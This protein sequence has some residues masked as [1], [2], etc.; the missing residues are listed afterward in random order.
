MR[1]RAWMLV[2]SS[3]ERTNSSS[4]NRL[5]CQSR[6]YRSRIRPALAWNCGSRGNIQQRCCHGRM[7][8]SCSQRHTVLLLIFA[9]RPERWACRAT[10]AT[11]SRD[12]GRPS[13]AGNSQAS[14]LTS[15]VS[16]GGEG[17]GTS[18]ADPLFQ[19]RQS[20]L[21]EALAPLADHLAPG[22]QARGDLVVVQ[23]VGGHENHLGPRDLEVRQRIFGRT[24]T[25]LGCLARGQNDTEW[26]F[27][28]HRRTL[29]EGS[30]QDAIRDRIWQ[31]YTLPY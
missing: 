4:R 28:R 30:R 25:H 27:P 22:V 13:V 20:L 16:P 12:S 26:A 10:S 6:S 29:L 3:V 17:P 7:A 5:P 9:T 1:S 24:P 11:L 14:A 18:W 2:F 19:A 23:A 31:A 8:S 15:T 21:E